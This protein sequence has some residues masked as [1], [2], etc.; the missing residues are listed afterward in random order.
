M[1]FQ[2]ILALLVQKILFEGEKRLSSY[3]ILNMFTAEIRLVV[4]MALNI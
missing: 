1:V 2:T 4:N 3:Q